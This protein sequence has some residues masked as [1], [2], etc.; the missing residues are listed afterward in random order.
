M[1]KTT[2]IAVG[3]LCLLCAN[4][5]RMEHHAGGPFETDVGRRRHEERMSVTQALGKDA[6]GDTEETFVDETTSLLGSSS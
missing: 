2:L 1:F 6:K 4:F 3:V 5:W